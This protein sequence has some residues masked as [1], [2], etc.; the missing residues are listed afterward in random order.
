MKLRI[1]KIAATVLLLVVT[2]YFAILIGTYGA[3]AR[4]TYVNSIA[5]QQEDKC[6]SEKDIDCFRAH[7]LLRAGIAANSAKSSLDRHVTSGVASELEQYLEWYKSV[8]P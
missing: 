3:L 6:W 1:I 5:I 2:H 7:W 8:E 4:S